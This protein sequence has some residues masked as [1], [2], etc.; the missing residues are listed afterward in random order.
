M[1]EAQK[2][3]LFYILFDISINIPAIKNL[4][5][6]FF[7]KGTIDKKKLQSKLKSDL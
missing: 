3:P 1:Y 7:D 2:S 6:A 4:N 5:V